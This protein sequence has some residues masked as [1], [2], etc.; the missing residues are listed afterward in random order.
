MSSNIIA[1]SSIHSIHIIVIIIAQTSNSD[2]NEV[3]V[4]RCI[5]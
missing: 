1:F 3:V 2:Y 5:N 4:S